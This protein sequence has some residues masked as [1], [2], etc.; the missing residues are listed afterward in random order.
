MVDANMAGTAGLTME[1]LA[2]ALGKMPPEKQQEVLAGLFADYE[3]EEPEIEQMAARARE[4]RGAKMPGGQTVGRRF[5]HY[6]PPSMM[7][8]LGA[9]GQ[10]LA[11]GLMEN[12]VQNR[13][14]ARTAKRSSTMEALAKIFGGLGGAGVPPGGGAPPMWPGT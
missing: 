13:L 7:G 1:T 6:V 8:Q 5:Q 11:G 3:G 4:L 14:G 12:Q 2:A 10:Q 9:A